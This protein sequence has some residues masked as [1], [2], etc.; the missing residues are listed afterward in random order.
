[1]QACRADAPAAQ[2]Y[3][4]KACLE[5]ADLVRDLGDSCKAWDVLHSEEAQWLRHANSRNRARI[6]AMVCADMGLRCPCMLDYCNA[7]R[8]RVMAVVT[9]ET[10]HHDM[11]MPKRHGHVIRCVSA[12]TRRLGIN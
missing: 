1:M 7:E 10:L 9:C 4:P 5:F 6:L 3:L 2:T 8:G 12:L 11:V